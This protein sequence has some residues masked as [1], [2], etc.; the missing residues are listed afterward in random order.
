[1]DE[2]FKIRTKYPRDIIGGIEIETCVDAEKMLQNIPNP[3]P[4]MT[5]EDKLG[6]EEHQLYWRR[7]GYIWEEESY[8]TPHV[9]DRFYAKEGRG[10][11]DDEVEVIKRKWKDGNTII[12]YKPVGEDGKVTE[13]KF[14][15]TL[16][17]FEEV[18]TYYETKSEFQRGEW[19]YRPEEKTTLHRN[20]LNI[21]PY[22]ATGDSSIVCGKWDETVAVEY[23]TKDPY[24]IVDIMDGRTKIGRATRE[25]MRLAYACHENSRGDIS[26]GT[27]VHM[28]YNCI[29]KKDY[30]HFNK[31]MRYLWIAYYQPYCLVE[32]Y[33]FQ[34]RDDNSYSKVST[35]EPIGKYEMFNENPSYDSEFWHFEFRGYGEMRSGWDDVAKKYLKILMN[36]WITALDYYKQNKISEVENIE[37]VLS[38]K[39]RDIESLP[40]ELKRILTSVNV[41]VRTSISRYYRLEWEIEAT[42]RVFRPKDWREDLNFKIKELEVDEDTIIVFVTDEMWLDGEPLEE[43]TRENWYMNLN[44]WMEK[45]DIRGILKDEIHGESDEFDTL[46]FNVREDQKKGFSK[47]LKDLRRSISLT[48]C[49]TRYR[50][51]TIAKLYKIAPNVFQIH[52][53]YEK[54]VLIPRSTT[55]KPGVLQ[56]KF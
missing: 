26:C 32:F 43:R 19:V 20:L 3:M 52:L 34:N 49:Y 27:H 50:C 16:E 8:E 44:Y 6:N 29:T 1:M 12:G 13:K 14:G 48:G 5:Y 56:L 9:G 51:K 38:G 40:P 39:P 17:D 41:T 30:P 31:V 47:L 18:Y 45:Y 37:I 4:R 28:S 25:I 10:E 21:P 53:G 55:V 22:E 35:D 54:E 46:L 7:L 23:V 36:L 2:L 11:F 42:E 15:M 24:P 33:T